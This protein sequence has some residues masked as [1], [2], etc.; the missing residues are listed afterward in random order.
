M[1][2]PAELWCVVAPSGITATF[3]TEAK[4]CA[5]VASFAPGIRERLDVVRYVRADPS[6]STRLGDG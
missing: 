6:D 1:T 2:A 4:A 5:H 3:D